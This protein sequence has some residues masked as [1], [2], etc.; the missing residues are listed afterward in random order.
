MEGSPV[1]KVEATATAPDRWRVRLPKLD[2]RT[3]LRPRRRGEVAMVIQ[4]TPGW[5]LLQ[6]K[7][8]YP[9]GVF[10]LPTGTVHARETPEAAMLRELH[11]EANLVPG[12]VRRLCRVD[13]EITGGRKDFFTEVFLIE[14]P[15]GELKPNDPSEAIDAWREAMIS[16]L[17]TVAEELRRLDPPWRGWGLL[18]SVVHDIVPPL[19]G[20]SS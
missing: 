4:R 5:V 16:E 8:H 6:T 15:R 9:P 13:Y 1:A 3:V 7:G 10:R 11:E 14:A 19:L 2:Y 18:R 20:V 17:T 12:A